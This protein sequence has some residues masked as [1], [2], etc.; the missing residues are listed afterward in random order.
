MRLGP[1]VCGLLI[2]IIYLMDF[3]YFNGVLKVDHAVKS[4]IL[5]VYAYNACAVLCLCMSIHC[6]NIVIEASTY[7]M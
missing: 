5:G 1:L 3:L 4:C 6:R 7:C 2:I